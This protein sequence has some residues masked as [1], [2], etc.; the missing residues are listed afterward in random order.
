MGR[1]AGTWL[2]CVCISEPL[3]WMYSA[4]TG[5]IASPPHRMAAESSNSF[6]DFDCT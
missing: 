4:L 2:R 6:I 3:F 5:D 1:V